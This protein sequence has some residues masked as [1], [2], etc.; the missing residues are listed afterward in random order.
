MSTETP[1]ID[2]IRT[3]FRLPHPLHKA[4]RLEAAESERDMTEIILE[5]LSLR[6]PELVKQPQE[7]QQPA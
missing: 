4:I 1:Q 3:T 2:R 7:Q 5:Q 6:Y